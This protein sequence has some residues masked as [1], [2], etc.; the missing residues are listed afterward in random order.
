MNQLTIYSYPG[1][2]LP[3]S[4]R[5]TGEGGVGVVG[6]RVCDISIPPPEIILHCS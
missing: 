5:L 4:G 6:S 2:R 3:D 1:Q